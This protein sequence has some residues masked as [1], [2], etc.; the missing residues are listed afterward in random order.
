MTSGAGIL[1]SRPSRPAITTPRTRGLGRRR[2]DERRPNEHAFLDPRARQ[3]GFLE[4]ERRVEVAPQNGQTM[5]P[6]PVVATHDGAA[7]PREQHAANRQRARLDAPGQ[8]Q[9]SQRRERARVDGVA[10]QLVAW[11]PRTVE[12]QHARARPRQDRGRHGASRT[13]AGDN[14]VKQ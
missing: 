2:F 8:I 4:H 14:D 11:K 7:L 6:R 10:A 3:H 9:P 12:Q 13:R 5:N 1:I